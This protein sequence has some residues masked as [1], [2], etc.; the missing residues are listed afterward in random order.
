[1][2]LLTRAA[3]ATTTLARC[4]LKNVDAYGTS[5]SRFPQFAR[6]QASHTA[7]DAMLIPQFHVYAT[8][9]IAAYKY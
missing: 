5:L 3:Q 1:M 8:D 9:I 2:L 6:R 7:V 4:Q